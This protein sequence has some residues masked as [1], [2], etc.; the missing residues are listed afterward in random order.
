METASIDCIEQ[1]SFF[2]MKGITDSS[3]MKWKFV[4]KYEMEI[5]KSFL[6]KYMY[7]KGEDLLEYFRA[8]RTLIKIDDKA[9]VKI[10]FCEKV[11]LKERKNDSEPEIMNC[12]L[13]G[14][15]FV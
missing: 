3:K 4:L 2:D 9:T 12:K 13:I 10:N 6:C 8:N 14:A 7:S 5:K 1:H 11:S 15:H